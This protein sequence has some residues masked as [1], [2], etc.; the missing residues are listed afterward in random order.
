MILF[1]VN[2]KKQKKKNK[3]KIESDHM[4]LIDKIHILYIKAQSSFLYQNSIL[5]SLKLHR[6]SD[7]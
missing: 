7:E 5:V 6:G 4:M 1:I 3:E 2:L